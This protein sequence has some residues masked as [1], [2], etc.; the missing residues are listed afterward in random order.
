M[1]VRQVIANEQKKTS[2]KIRDINHD[3]EVRV[4]NQEQEDFKK[5]KLLEYVNVESTA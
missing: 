4:Q 1:N 2:K 5:A 3:K